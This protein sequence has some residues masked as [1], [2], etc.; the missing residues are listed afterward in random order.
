MFRDL[1]LLQVAADQSGIRLTVDDEFSSLGDPPAGVGR[2]KLH[3]RALPADMEIFRLAPSGQCSKGPDI[4]RQVTPDV[5]RWQPG[6]MHAGDF[7]QALA[8][9]TMRRRRLIA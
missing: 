7:L 8:A 4:L 3:V 6:V 2:H 5:G 1:E 9:P